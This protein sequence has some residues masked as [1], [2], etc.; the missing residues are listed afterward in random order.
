LLLNI[1]RIYILDYNFR[2]RSNAIAKNAKCILVILPVAIIW[3]L[4]GLAQADDPNF[5]IVD[6]NEVPD[7]LSMLASVTQANFEKINTWQGRITN[8]DIITIRGEQAA[9]YLKES[10][11][12]E[13]NNLPNE[14][15]R[16]ANETIEYEIDVENNRFHSMSKYTKP[17]FYLDTK[18]DKIY[19]LQ[20]GSGESIFI[21][22]SKY[23]TWIQPLRETKDNVVLSRLAIKDRAGAAAVTDPRDRFYMGNKTL[24]LSYLQLS[25]SL[26]IPGIE[27]YGVVIKKKTVGDN[28][29]YR[30]EM[31]APGKDKPFN[32]DTLS[33]EAGYNR[34]CIENWYDNGSL[35]AKTT[36]EFVNI[37]GVFLPRKWKM[38]QYFQDGGLL[39]RENCTIENQQI[40]V[41]IPDSTFSVHT[42]LHNGDKFRDNIAHKEYKYQD[43]NL[44]PITDVNK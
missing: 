9:K 34:T 12:A 22:T 29:T 20:W 31:S 17:P 30:V 25:Q 28:I 1:L 41:S 2:K 6:A 18:N 16:V 39:H 33:S 44:V 5:K 14:I 3:S 21:V 40:N 15:Q 10:T 19:P 26:R 23:Q 8:E 35:R 38:S 13:P 11:D 27:H 7:V 36:I 24:W 42:Y 43:A 37:Q 32:I 4:N